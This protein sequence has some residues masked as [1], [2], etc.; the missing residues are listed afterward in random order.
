MY[1]KTNIKYLY[2]NL[3]NKYFQ[4][5][6]HGYIFKI[7][8]YGRC[9]FNFKGRLYF[10]DSFSKHGE[11]TSQYDHKTINNKPFN[12]NYSFD[13]CRLSTTILDELNEFDE[14]ENIKACEL[15]LHNNFIDLLLNILKD[16]NKEYIY[17][18]TN[19]TF[20]LY[21]DITNKAINGVP[22]DIINNDIFKLFITQ[23][24]E[25]KKYYTL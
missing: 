25:D 23:K 24:F 19:N 18:G 20:Q 8:D 13:L 11:A 16:D 21:I 22:K 7:I 2:Y 9:I 6:T 3:N 14:K 10:N 5:P 15:E 1:V 17:D 4:V 12:P